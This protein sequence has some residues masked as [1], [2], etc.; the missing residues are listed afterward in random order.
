MY[1][2]QSSGSSAR[3]NEQAKARFPFRSSKEE[4][5]PA[6]DPDFVRS[7]ASAAAIDAALLLRNGKYVTTGLMCT[8][9]HAHL[10]DSRFQWVRPQGSLDG[11]LQL[12]RHHRDVETERGILRAATTT[13]IM[14]EG[15]NR[16]LLSPRSIL[17]LVQLMSIITLSTHISCPSEPDT[18]VRGQ[19]SASR[20]GWESSWRA[21]SG[22]N[23]SKRVSHQIALSLIS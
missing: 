15:V 20:T 21:A 4:R 10:P 7:T 16:G 17:A 12:W 6:E 9:W 22:R 13:S 5:Q 2:L 23:K 3:G 1:Q 19:P 8:E 14:L 11:V 18:D